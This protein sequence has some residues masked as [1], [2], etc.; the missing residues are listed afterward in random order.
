MEGRPSII[1]ESDLIYPVLNKHVNLLL[2]DVGVYLL[3]HNNP[4]AALL[5]F[6]QQNFEEGQSVEVSRLMNQVVSESVDCVDLLAKNLVI[7]GV[8]HA[9]EGSLV[10]VLQGVHQ[11]GLLHK[12]FLLH[13]HHE[14]HLLGFL[15]ETTHV[16]T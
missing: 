2:A 14:L 13:L 5:E 11:E 9:F 15:A 4:S 6:G 8:Q 10:V 7:H 16:I 3:L 12:V 1:R